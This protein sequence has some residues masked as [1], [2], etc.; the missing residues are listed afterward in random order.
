MPIVEIQGQ[1]WFRKN[2]ILIYLH[3]LLKC[4]YLAHVTMSVPMCINQ[5]ILLQA[6]CI[7]NFCNAFGLRFN[8]VTHH[9]FLDFFGTCSTLFAAP[10]FHSFCIIITDKNFEVVLCVCTSTLIPQDNSA[11]SP[12]FSR[13]D[14]SI[15]TKTMLTLIWLFSQRCS[16]IQYR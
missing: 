6:S 10:S 13:S 3:V 15:Q 14:S 5:Q 8:N 4:S 12:V 11:Q 2:G 1:F 16:C 7:A 9:H